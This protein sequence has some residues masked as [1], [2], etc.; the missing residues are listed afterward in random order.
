MSPQGKT[1]LVVEIPCR[2][3]DA[4]WKKSDEELIVRVGPKLVQ[5]GLIKKD[6][7]IDSVV[8]R[9]PYAYPVLEAG[10]EEKLQHAAKVLARFSNLVLS[11]RSGLFVYGH[12]HD[13]MA[14]GKEIIE[15]YRSELQ[16]G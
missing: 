16:K 14:M 4:V 1:S 3:A 13:M 6:E 7:I 9:I 12:I 8:K 10:F 15:R 2:Q 5:T 11:G